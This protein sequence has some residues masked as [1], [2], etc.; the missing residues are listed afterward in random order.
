MALIYKARFD[1]LYINNF[2]SWIVYDP[3]KFTSQV[4]G[5]VYTELCM[6]TSG[7][8]DTQSK[9]QGV[10]KKNPGSYPSFATETCAW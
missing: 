9:I 5:K 10:I 2:Q 4:L 1:R 6:I 3:V 7:G 8:L